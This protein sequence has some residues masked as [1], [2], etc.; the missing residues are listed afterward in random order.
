MKVPEL[1]Q[2]DTRR[3]DVVLSLSQNSKWLSNASSLIRRWPLAIR[4]N[5]LKLQFGGIHIGLSEI[6]NSEPYFGF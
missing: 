2:H 5:D 3:A 1:T 6:G 4:E